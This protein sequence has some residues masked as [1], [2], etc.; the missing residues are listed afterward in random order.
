M[1]DT[2]HQRAPDVTN[3]S[4]YSDP[5][6]FYMAMLEDI[7]QA[8]KSIY[9]E[10]YKFGN[11]PIGE[12]FRD[13]LTRK[14]REGIEIKLLLDAWGTSLSSSF[15]G[16]MIRNGVEIRYFK[17]LRLS[18][19]WMARH[20][21]R[22]HRKLLIIDDETC[23]LGSA[24]L[25]AYSLNWREFVVRIQGGLTRAFR[26][27][28]TESRRIYNKLYFNTKLYSRVIN[29]GDFRIIRDVPSIT[30]QRVKKAFED[31]IRKAKREILIETPYFLP[32]FLLRKLLMDAAKRGVQVT[33]CTPDQSDVGIVDVL[34]SK[35]LG[36]MHKSGIDF[37][38]FVPYNLHAKLMIVD[39][40]VFTF[41]SSNFDYRSFRYMHEIMLFGKHREMVDAFRKHV[42]ETLN[43]CVVF[44]YVKWKRR[45][46]L[47]K[48]FENLLVPFRH[49]L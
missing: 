36:I 25:T 6:K 48:V 49:F 13:A 38:F 4:C 23:Y 24:N 19:D 45:P 46:L 30:R 27:S 1:T 17:R 29:Y 12:K 22:D 34:R 5:L 16:E 32:G 43:D 28:F 7:G 39:N 9:M 2:Q 15:F 44:D 26:R 11:D 18:Y 37:R 41:G 33:V 3:F 31:L 20:H 35:Y 21:S 40:E 42:D 47:H 10:M 14:S 8:Q